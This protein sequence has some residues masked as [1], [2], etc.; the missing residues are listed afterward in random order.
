MLNI[1][2]INIPNFCPTYNHTGIC[3]I[4]VIINT[5]IANNPFNKGILMTLL[6]G[7]IDGSILADKN[8][9]KLEI[10]KFLEVAH[11]TCIPVADTTPL[12][13]NQATVPVAA[14]VVPKTNNAKAGNIIFVLFFIKEIFLS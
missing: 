14:A 13:A 10:I 3:H 7:I 6:I 8:I 11:L 5:I 12:A 9:I 1:T 2:L 4:N